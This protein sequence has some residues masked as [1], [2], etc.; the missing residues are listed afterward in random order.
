M[1]AIAHK[2]RIAIYHHFDKDDVIDEHVLYTLRHIQKFGCEI[3]FVS[4]SPLGSEETSKLDGLVSEVTLRKNLGYDFAGWKQILLAKGKKFFADYDELLIINSTV[5]GPLFPLTDMFQAMEGKGYDFW[6]PT[7]HTAAYGIPKHVQPYFLV[8][9]KELHQSNAFWSY[10][11]TIKETYADLCDV[12]VHGEIR[13]TQ[14]WEAAGFK[15]GACAVMDDEREMRELGIYEPFVMHAADFLIEKHGLSMVKVKA[16]YKYEARPFTL[17]RQIFNALDLKKSVYPQELIMQHQRR[18]SPLSWHKNLPTTLLVP[19]DKGEPLKQVGLNKIGVF[20]HFFY[21]DMFEFAIKYLKNI[22][23]SFDMYITTVSDEAVQ[24]IK[25]LAEK[26]DWNL[27]ALK[28]K[29]IENRGRDYAPWL[30]EFREEH[31]ACDLAL[32]IHLKKHSH[33]QE[34]FGRKWNY[35]MYECLLKSPRYVSEIINSF[36]ENDDL[37]II[38]PPY[39][40]VYNMVFPE[41]YYGS[42]EDQAQRQQ[43]LDKFGLCPPSENSQP[44][45]S[46]GGMSW[47]RPAA[48]HRLLTWDIDYHKF[49]IEP[50]PL[51]GTIGHGLERVIPYIAQ[52]EGYTYRL[53]MPKS[54]LLMGYQMY[55]DRR[56]SCFDKA[57]AESIHGHPGVSKSIMNLAVSIRHGYHRSF[58][59]MARKTVRIE[60]SLGRFLKRVL[61]I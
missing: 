20:G 6:A 7:E 25:Y 10:W 8:V 14:E 28:V 12:V 48:L 53:A 16:F 33:Y 36:A 54:E 59:V 21:P 2:K 50:H 13:L 45:F 24:E 30:L 61:L 31:L 15:S 39:S 18:V 11:H 3:L 32:K 5:Y 41:G 40:P 17:T 22:P 43:I 58:P 57:L 44:I 37:G 9:N 49:P 34:A 19:E 23:V 38:F 42:C 51:S 27:N 47:Y 35:Y 4:N 52:A 56:M 55:E 46:A 60:R 29:K 26:T 1:N